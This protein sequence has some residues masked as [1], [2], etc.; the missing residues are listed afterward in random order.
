[1][2]QFIPTVSFATAATSIFHLS[3]KLPPH[4]VASVAQISTAIG[5]YVISE[6]AKQH[7]FRFGPLQPL[8]MAEDEHYGET[9]LHGTAVSTSRP[10]PSSYPSHQHGGRSSPPRARSSFD[11]ERIPFSWER[12]QRQTETFLRSIPTSDVK[13]TVVTAGVLAGI[14]FFFDKETRWNCMKSA[15]LISLS[16]FALVKLSPLRPGLY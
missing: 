6:S 4:V 11:E 8:D 5:L 3:D 12:F 7:P 15:A 2:T 1:M 9:H 14:G 13:W 16:Q 10:H